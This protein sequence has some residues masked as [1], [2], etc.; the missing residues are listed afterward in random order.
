MIILSKNRLKKTI[1]AKLSEDDF[2]KISCAIIINYDTGYYDDHFL[3]TITKNFLNIYT[4]KFNNNFDDCCKYV[5]YI[6]NEDLKILE[7]QSNNTR[8]GKIN[9]IKNKIVKTKLNF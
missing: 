6:L 5:D 4:I 2:K 9:K 8:V 3:L 7:D 1:V